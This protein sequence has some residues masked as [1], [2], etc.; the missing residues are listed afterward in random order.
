MPLEATLSDAIEI[1]GPIKPLSGKVS[2]LRYENNG[3]FT[4][5]QINYSSNSKR[6]SRNNP[7]IKSGDIIA[8]RNSIIGKSTELIREVTMPFVGIYS[9]KELIEN[10]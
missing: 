9:T 6:G 10:F 4:K 7:F 8:V 2:I 5:K 1:S 3:T